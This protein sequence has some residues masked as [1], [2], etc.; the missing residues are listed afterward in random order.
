LSVTAHWSHELENPNNVRK[1]GR[2]LLRGLVKLAHRIT[3]LTN[4]AGLLDGGGTP[5][6]GISPVMKDSPVFGVRIDYL[7]STCLARS[8]LE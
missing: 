3:D 2:I 8:F 4:A 7:R 1:T 5:A 6:D